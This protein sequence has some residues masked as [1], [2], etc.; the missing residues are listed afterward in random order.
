MKAAILFTGSGPIVVVTLCDSLTDP[1]VI[2]R[3]AAKGVE[4]FL[5]FELPMDKV[6]TRY[7]N[8]FEVVCEDFHETD[9]LRVVD[10]NGHRALSLFNF[11]EFSSQVYHEPAE[12]QPTFGHSE[13]V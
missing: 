7:G 5:G 1:R 6:R 11:E 8:H 9:D 4:K 2:R 3:L 13:F 12:P 10:Y